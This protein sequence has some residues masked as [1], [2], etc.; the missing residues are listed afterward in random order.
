M[1]GPREKEGSGVNHLEN[2]WFLSGLKSLSSGEFTT[3]R[4][5]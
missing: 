5:G 3:H 1:S 4:V 2:H